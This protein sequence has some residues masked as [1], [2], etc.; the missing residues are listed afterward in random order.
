M[1]QNIKDIELNSNK[2]K[3]MKE[4]KEELI[5]LKSDLENII[6]SL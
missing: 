2:M 4:L 1:E 5:K 3:E 6:S